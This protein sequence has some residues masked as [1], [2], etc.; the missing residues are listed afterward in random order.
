MSTVLF[1]VVWLLGAVLVSNVLFALLRFACRPHLAR[2][3]AWRV[4]R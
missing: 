1:A 2:Y 4:R 3:L